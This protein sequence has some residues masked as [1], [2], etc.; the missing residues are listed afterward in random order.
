MVDWGSG[1]PRVLAELIGA[2]AVLLGL[3][4]VGLE[5][6]QNT[7]A[8]QASTLQGMVDLSTNY[9]IDTSLDPEFVPL[10]IKAQAD[11]DQLNEVEALRVQ[12]LIR[13]QWLRYQSAFQHWRRGSL[14]DVD[15]ESFSRFICANI[16]NVG[17]GS[18]AAIQVKFWQ[19]ERTV[20]TDDFVA[21]VE[22]C[23]PDLAEAPD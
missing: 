3:L 16:T 21:Y 13:S 4:F 22:S 1:K 23:R 12:R 5:L 2:I 9:L 10:L 20:L 6:R 14:G 19:N 15:W 11:P 7:A 18:F 17:P 8:V